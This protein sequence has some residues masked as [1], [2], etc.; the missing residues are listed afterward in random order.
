MTCRYRIVGAFSSNRPRQGIP[1]KLMQRRRRRRREGDANLKGLS[2]PNVDLTTYRVDVFSS[3]I[4]FNQLES[5][6][7]NLVGTPLLFHLLS[8]NRDGSEPAL[9]TILRFAMAKGHGSTKV[10]WRAQA[11]ANNRDEPLKTSLSFRERLLKSLRGK[12]KGLV[13][14]WKHQDQA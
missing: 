7:H 2:K 4:A 1:D 14:R 10:Y 9:Q 5:L 11:D 12:Y 3:F 6:L 13:W 8:Q